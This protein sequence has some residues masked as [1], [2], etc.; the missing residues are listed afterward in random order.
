MGGERGIRWGMMTQFREFIYTHKIIKRKKYNFII[1]QNKNIITLT[2][3]NAI[4]IRNIYSI[5]CSHPQML[6]N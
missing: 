5:I 2:G 3:I 4:Q 1:H 6:I